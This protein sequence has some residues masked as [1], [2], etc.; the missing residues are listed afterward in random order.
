[1][2]EVALQSR[3]GRAGYRRQRQASQAVLERGEFSGRVDEPAFDQCDAADQTTEIGVSGER[4]EDDECAE[5]MADEDR[6]IE[7]ERTHEA[8]E[9]GREGREIVAVVRFV[10]EPVPTEVRRNDVVPGG[11]KSFGNGLPAPGG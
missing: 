3:G 9:V 5:R 11:R 1:M 4:F 8:D 6:P 2:A 10:G 7:L